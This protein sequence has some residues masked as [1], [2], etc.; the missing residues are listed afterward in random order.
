MESVRVGELDISFVQQG[1]GPPLVLLH[2]GLS[3]SREWRRQI[4]ALSTEF[5]VM[6]WDAP[7]SGASS[8]P[9]GEFTLADFSDSLAGLVDALG[10]PP[11]AFAGNSWGGTLALEHYRRHADQVKALI[12]CDTYAGWIGS[13]GQAASNEPPRSVPEGVGDANT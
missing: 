6:A 1:N 5:T 4:S 7:A 3:D 13:I 10:L 2:G 9:F 12:L 11:A 8:D